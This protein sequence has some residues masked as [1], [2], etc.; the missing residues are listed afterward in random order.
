MKIGIIADLHIDINYNKGSDVLRELIKVVNKDHL[1]Y[2]IRAGD[3]SDN[4]ETTLEIREKLNYNSSAY[5][6]FV[7]GNHDLWNKKHPTKKPEEIYRKLQCNPGN[8]CLNPYSINEEWVII[9]DIGW[10]DYSFGSDRFTEEDYIKGRYRGRVWKD[11]LFVPWNKEAK[12]IH[13]Y[14]CKKIKKQI[15]SN[16]NKNII[17]VTHF[18]PHEYFLVPEER[19]SWVFF[20]A[21]L[22]S[23]DYARL[24][25]DYNVKYSIF[26]HI[27]H[28]VNQ[29]IKGTEFI[30]NS[31]GYVNQWNTP[32]DTY[33][34]I[35]KSLV[36][37]KI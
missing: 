14:F 5:I 2:L 37:L 26:G 35:N 30:G 33:S 19:D 20:N 7:P 18:V 15:Q 23:P 17:L 27:H 10:Y 3:I 11:T 36:T 29:S 13:Q 24:A 34:E 22:G 31:L 32:E 25:L 9:G 4:D 1:A 28:K 6:L 12:Q 8:L 16:K 21:Y